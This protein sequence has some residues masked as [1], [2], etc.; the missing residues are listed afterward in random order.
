[1]R[2]TVQHQHAKAE[3]SRHFRWAM[4]QIADPDVEDRADFGLEFEFVDDE[5]ERPEVMVSARPRRMF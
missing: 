2:R 3:M 4:Q 1:M 5:G